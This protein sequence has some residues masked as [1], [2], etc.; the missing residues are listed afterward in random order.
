MRV[1]LVLDCLLRRRI[2][3]RGRLV[4]YQDARILE[5][6]ARDRDA[7]LLAAGELQPALAHPRFVAFRQALDEV[8]NVRRARGFD[9]FLARGVRAPVED[10]VVDRVVEEHGVLRHD[11]DRRAQARL[12][13]IADVDAVHQDAARSPTS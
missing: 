5:D 11:A 12:L 2:E 10:V 4:E 6:G 13:E 1:E 3:R 7:L 8:V 9:D